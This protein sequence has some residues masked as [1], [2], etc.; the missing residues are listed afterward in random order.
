M[1]QSEDK[2]TFQSTFKDMM[3]QPRHALE[4]DD[5]LNNS[6]ISNQISAKDRLGVYHNNIIGSLSEA[7]RATFPLLENLVGEDF[8]KA[9]ARVF[10]FNNPPTSGCIH[11]YGKGFDAFIAT[12]EP[13]KNIP[14]LSHIATLELAMNTAY[15]A[16]DD[17]PL[18]PNGLTH[19]QSESLTNTL[20]PL[21]QSATLIQSC[22]P[23]HDI[24]AFCLKETDQ[25]PDLSQ[26]QSYSFLVTR[27]KLDVIIL[28]LN[29]AEYIMLQRLHNSEP[30]GSALENTVAQ[31][32]TFDFTSFLQKHIALE[33]FTNVTSNKN[34]T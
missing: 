10:I 15:Y 32:Q 13:A 21:R 18:T 23:L 3:L 6:F 26:K 31:D 9:M 2:E 29:A 7:I 20:L 27:P 14:Y 24:R 16:P 28:P 19:L 4:N 22:F 11:H 5:R 30:L 17:A 34:I 25:A 33:T 1:P 8:L 12:Y